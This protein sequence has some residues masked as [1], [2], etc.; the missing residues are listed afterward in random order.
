ML[1]L[2]LLQSSTTITGSTR[3][4]LTTA[5]RSTLGG[6]P[7]CSTLCLAWLVPQAA[8]IAC[9]STAG[10]ARLLDVT[11]G[12]KRLHRQQVPQRLHRPVHWRNASG[13]ARVNLARKQAMA[14][15]CMHACV[16]VCVLVVLVL[17]LVVCV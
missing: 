6:A 3:S 8:S 7:F 10:A 15:A 5:V 13:R 17:V 2:Q 14:Q 4:N 11:C 1:Q 16:C 12:H 9:P